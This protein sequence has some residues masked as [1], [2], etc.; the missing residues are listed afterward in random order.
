MTTNSLAILGSW[1]Q[2][3]PDPD[4]ATI[5]IRFESDGTFV[6]SIDAQEIALRWRTE[7][8]TLL[9]TRPNAPGEQ[10]NA[11]RIEG[12][13]QRLVLGTHVYVRFTSAS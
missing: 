9:T 1:Q 2:I 4:P 6:Y 10:V 12:S 8:E 5:V 13:P 7:G 3:E 11:F